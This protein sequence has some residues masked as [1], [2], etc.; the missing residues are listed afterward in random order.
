MSFISASARIQLG[1][2]HKEMS[3]P[4]NMAIGATFPDVIA[5]HKH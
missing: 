5:R 4:Q 3:E 2:A 1:K